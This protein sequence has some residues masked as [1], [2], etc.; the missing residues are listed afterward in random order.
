MA[1]IHKRTIKGLGEQS[2]IVP[3]YRTTYV[4]VNIVSSSDPACTFTVQVK[5]DGASAFKNADGDN[6]DVKLN[7]SATFLL[8]DV[9]EVKIVPSVATARYEARVNTY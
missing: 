4:S 9:N 6:S 8:T 7:E 1:D 2:T 5:F 3:S